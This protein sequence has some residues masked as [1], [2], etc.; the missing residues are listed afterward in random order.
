MTD[1]LAR[2]ERLK[3]EI[4]RL[5]AGDDEQELNLA[6]GQLGELQDRA[7]GYREQ[8]KQP[9]TEWVRDGVPGTGRVYGKERMG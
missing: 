1:L 5:R 9:Y 6:L 8:P 7:N 2:I 4:E 3:A